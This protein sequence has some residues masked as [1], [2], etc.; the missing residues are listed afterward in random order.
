MVIVFLTDNLIA[1]ALPGLKLVSPKDPSATGIGGY[2]QVPQH[3]EHHREAQDEAGHADDQQCDPV[4]LKEL[5][6]TV[7]L[8]RCEAATCCVAQTITTC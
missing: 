7:L 8:G 1:S 3:P 6:H 2:P 4:A 5:R